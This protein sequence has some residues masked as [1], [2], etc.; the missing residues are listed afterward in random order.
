[1]P[2]HD[3]NGEPAHERATA[4]GQG[5]RFSPYCSDLSSKKVLTST[6]LPMTAADVLDASNWCW[7]RKT[8][9]QLGPDRKFAHPED[10]RAGRGCFESVFHGAS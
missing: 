3:S 8:G 10:C 2:D 5:P 1:M 4:A 7:C 9:H 6:G